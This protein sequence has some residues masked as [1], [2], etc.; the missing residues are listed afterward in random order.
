MQDD[1]PSKLVFPQKLWWIPSESPDL[2]PIENKWYELKEF[3]R[4]DAKP[5]SKHQ[6]VEGIEVLGNRHQ[7]KM[8]PL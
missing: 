2:N 6:F 5:M 1:D 3:I 4:R 7:R 8:H